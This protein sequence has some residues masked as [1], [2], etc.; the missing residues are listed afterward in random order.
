VNRYL[1]YLTEW[2]APQNV[3][4]FMRP[5]SLRS[6]PLFREAFSLALSW[7][8]PWP[9]SRLLSALGPVSEACVMCDPDM[10]EPDPLITIITTQPLGP[11]Q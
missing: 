3:L 4:S 5:M 6:I 1:D 9:W 10:R 8:Y 2:H 11:R 7:L